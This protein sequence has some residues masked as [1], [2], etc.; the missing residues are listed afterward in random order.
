MLQEIIAAD[1][2]L[3]DASLGNFLRLITSCSIEKQ[4]DDSRIAKKI[5]VKTSLVEHAIYNICRA[6]E[7]IISSA[8]LQLNKSLQIDE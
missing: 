1:A 3:I 7:P 2:S 5:D 8:K 4:H 6:V